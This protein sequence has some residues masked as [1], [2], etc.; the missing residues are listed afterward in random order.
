MLRP[1]SLPCFSSGCRSAAKE[2]RRL[3]RPIP[4]KPDSQMSYLIPF[5]SFSIEKNSTRLSSSHNSRQHYWIR[6]A[7]KHHSQF[8]VCFRNTTK[9]IL[10]VS[11]SIKLHNQDETLELHF[12]RHRIQTPH[13]PPWLHWC[14]S[15]A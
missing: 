12:F 7:R 8:F 1:S 9:D 11:N 5:A 6:E 13:S 10:T 14:S 3:P 2:E 15:A 4:E